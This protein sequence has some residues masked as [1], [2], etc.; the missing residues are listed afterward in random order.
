MNH[1]ELPA[2][3]HSKSNWLLAVLLIGLSVAAMWPILGNDF[4]EWDD[5]ATIYARPALNPPSLRSLGDFW[6]HPYMSL[7]VPLTQTAWW[8][9]AAVAHV[10]TP[11]ASGAS[12]NPLPFHTVSLATH[13]ACVLIVMRLL[14]QIGA[15]ALPAAAGAAI[16]A[17]HPVQVEPVA[18]ASGLK[19]V[20]CGALTLSSVLLYIRAAKS[21]DHKISRRLRIL[22][23]LL[24]LLA[25]LSKPTAIV[26]PLFAATLD[27]LILR[28]PLRQIARS[29]A[30]FV[31][32]AIPCAIWTRH[33]QRAEAGPH[34]I[35]LVYAR[36]LIATDAVNFYLGKLIAPVNLTVIYGRRPDVVWQRGGWHWTWIGPAA[37]ALLAILARKRAAW[38]TAATL[39][40]LFG[41]LPVLGLVPFEFQLQSTVADHYLYLSMSGIALAVGFLC[42]R[43]GP[44]S[45]ALFGIVIL[46]CVVLSTRQALVWR[47]SVT[48]ARHGTQINPE[49]PDAHNTLA[50]ALDRAGEKNAAIAEYWQAIRI[51]PGFAP[52][53]AN[54]GALYAEQGQFDQA[55]DYFQGALQRDPNL[56]GAR[57]GLERAS[58]ERAATRPQNGQRPDS[59][60]RPER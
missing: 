21:T 22:A 2:F 60:G 24:F 25:M 38:L 47:N 53:W 45:W 26:M 10:D 33:F 39:L 55:I 49:D 31:L 4:V 12:L 36:P 28:R 7:Y 46:L 17:V 52:P 20:L 15:A 32:L 11:D 59:N 18:W 43:F 14:M 9:I 16:F 54:L 51:S 13:I 19:D 6:S 3:A 35:V 57:I 48:L 50:G 42:R 29:L 8:A 44:F 23:A 5:G 58:I 40:F 41:L 1:P 37:L 56:S 27:L 30:P 34:P